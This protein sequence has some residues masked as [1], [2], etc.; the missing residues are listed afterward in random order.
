MMT[1][2]IKN[3]DQSK[4]YNIEYRYGTARKILFVPAGA[5][6]PV[7]HSHEH[8]PIGNVKATVKCDDGVVMEESFEIDNPV[9]VHDGLCLK[10]ANCIEV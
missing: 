1:V 5:V 7:K 6:M 9:F 2:A 8:L 4:R 10:F 3:H